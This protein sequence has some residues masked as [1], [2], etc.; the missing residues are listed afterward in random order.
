[1]A[2]LDRALELAHPGP[3]PVALVPRLDGFAEQVELHAPLAL[4]GPD[5][6]QRATQ[7]SVPQERGQVVEGDDHADVVDRAVGDRT[8]RQVGK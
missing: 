2:A 5:V 3:L 6:G 8:G 1:V 7:F 4:T